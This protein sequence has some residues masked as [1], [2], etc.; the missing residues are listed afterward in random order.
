MSTHVP[1]VLTIDAR[2]LAIGIAAAR[3]NTV[4]VDALLERCLATLRASGA[5]EPVVVRVP[6]S[7]ELPVA[8]QALAHQRP[9]DALIALGVL[10]R[11][12]TIHYE[13]IAHS[14]AQALQTVALATRTPVVNGVLTV[15]NEAQ[16]ADR[17][18]GAADRGAEF[19]QAALAMAELSRKLRPTA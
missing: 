19:A 12:D 11:G 8:I 7:S 5:P 13:V 10:V 1:T 15:E 6:G 4:Y 18:Q 17:C 14:S 9:F 3:Y 16:A 2:E